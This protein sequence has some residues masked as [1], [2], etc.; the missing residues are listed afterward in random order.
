MNVIKKLSR[1]KGTKTYNIGSNH[2]ID[3]VE[4]FGETGLGTI[5]TVI[6]DK[7]DEVELRIRF[8]AD[9]NAIN[10]IV[11]LVKQIEL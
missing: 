4:D 3:F 10:Q 9:Q 7:K 11:H 1:I 6:Q 5:A 2:A 8:Y